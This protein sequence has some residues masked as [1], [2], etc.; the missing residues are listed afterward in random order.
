MKVLGVIP[1]RYASSRFPG[2]SLADVCGKSMIRR[3]YEQALKSKMLDQVVVATDDDRILNHVKEFGGDVLMTDQQHPNGTARC[4]EVLRKLEE[5]GHSF[6]VV[7]N[8]QGD[9]PFIQPEQIEKVIVPFRDNRVQISSLAAEIKNQET[10]FNPNEVKVVM[11]DNGFALYFSRHPIPYIRDAKEAD[12]LK[13]FSFYKHL[14]LYAFRSD[15]LK[16]I[17]QLIP[18][19]LEQAENLEQLRWLEKGYGIHMSLTDYEAQGIDTPEDL[20]KLINN[21]CE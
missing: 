6:D 3:V 19:Q 9:E 2:K 11:N 13:L 17:V 4:E 5:E 1:S 15:V 18:S 20:A 14:G 21:A 8:I 10:L 12:W 7:V 16:K